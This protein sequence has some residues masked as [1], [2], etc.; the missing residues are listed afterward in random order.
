M[1]YFKNLDIEAQE[2]ARTKTFELPNTITMLLERGC[3]HK[4]I[5]EKLDIPIK[6]VYY[7]D[8]TILRE[9]FK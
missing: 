2:I 1:G 8:N 6:W 3:T 4:Y 5:A 9:K 7:H